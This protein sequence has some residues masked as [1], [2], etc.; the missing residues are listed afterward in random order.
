MFYP[1]VSD[2]G[3]SGGNFAME[4]TNLVGY[5]PFLID[6]LMVFGVK[7][8]NMSFCNRMYRKPTK[9]QAKSRSEIVIK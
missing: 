2:I 6:C 8:K 3:E 9:K 1:K 5:S 7:I 4:I